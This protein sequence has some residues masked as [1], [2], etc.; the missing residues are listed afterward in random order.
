[1]TDP[2]SPVVSLPRQSEARIAEKLATIAECESDRRHRFG[3]PHDG[4]PFTLPSPDDCTCVWKDE[5]CDLCAAM[6]H[7]IDLLRSLTAHATE[8]EA[9]IARLRKDADALYRRLEQ[10]RDRGAKLQTQLD[11]LR[12]QQQT[13]VE[14]LKA[15]VNWID[16]DLHPGQEVYDRCQAALALVESPGAGEEQQ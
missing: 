2:R 15:A 7:D 3:C 11:T 9:E 14:A 12:D 4:D 16:V 6:M 1:M 13:L 10:A 5:P 8:Q